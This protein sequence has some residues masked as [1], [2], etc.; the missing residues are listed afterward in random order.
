MTPKWVVKS[1][2]GKVE[3]EVVVV[4]VVVVVMVRLVGWFVGRSFGRS[5]GRLVVW[6]F[7]VWLSACVRVCLSLC[8]GWLSQH[9]HMPPVPPPVTLTVLGLATCT[10]AGRRCPRR[11][12]LLARLSGWLFDSLLLDTVRKALPRGHS[13]H[14]WL[15][16]EG[17]LLGVALLRTTSLHVRI[18]CGN[19]PHGLR[20]VRGA[21]APHDCTRDNEEV[22][23]FR[24][25]F[26]VLAQL[27]WLLICFDAHHI[28]FS[29]NTQYCTS[30]PTPARSAAVRVQPRP[31]CLRQIT[32][33]LS[34]LTMEPAIPLG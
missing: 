34:K 7:G 33:C 28:C 20:T 2:S 13:A 9:S 17:R 25:H 31:S 16:Q 18:F 27:P 8:V 12:T 24:L 11:T 10:S 23:L 32:Q 15:Q 4:V 6:L 30:K 26:S 1:G 21:P 22:P 14:P 19:P 5:V 3:V 29:M